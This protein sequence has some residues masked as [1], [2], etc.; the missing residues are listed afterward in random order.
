M[1]IG[2]G[3]YI[4]FDNIGGRLRAE[5]VKLSLNPEEFSKLGKSAVATQNR[6]ELGSSLPKLEY[7]VELEAHGIDVC[8]IITGCRDDGSLGALDQSL[9]D[10]FS[11]LNDEQK[12]CYPA[13]FRCHEREACIIRRSAGGAS[14]TNSAQ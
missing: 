2:Q 10:Q 8:Y 11:F 7:L 9:L 4:N 14:I 3:K 5:R 6:Y 13:P 1:I 12:G